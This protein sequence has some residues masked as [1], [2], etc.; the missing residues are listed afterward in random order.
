MEIIDFFK[1]ELA[2]IADF[3]TALI[4]KLE[5][6]YSVDKVRSGLFS[7]PHIRRVLKLVVKEMDIPQG[8]MFNPIDHPYTFSETFSGRE[9][10]VLSAYC[11]PERKDE[12]LK[13]LRSKFADVFGKAEKRAQLNMDDYQKIRIF[14]KGL[15]NPEKTI[16][17]CIPEGVLHYFLID[18]LDD[19]SLSLTRETISRPDRCEI[20]SKLAR[21]REY[22]E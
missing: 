3:D 7:Q 18:S 6:E 15:Y 20:L 19:I 14:A 5:R 4:K 17:I 12:C 21:I 1:K 13:L 8:L 11:A 10:C 2:G 16:A 22:L 9:F